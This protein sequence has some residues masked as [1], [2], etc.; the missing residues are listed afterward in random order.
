MEYKESVCVCGGGACAFEGGAGVLTVGV[1]NACGGGLRGCVSL[2]ALQAAVLLWR[3]ACVSA[4][5]S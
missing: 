2:L 1:V 4:G 3:N 5:V